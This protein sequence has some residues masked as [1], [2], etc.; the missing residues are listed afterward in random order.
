MNGLKD[1][2]DG[3]IAD[4]DELRTRLEYLEE[5]EASR[6]RAYRRLAKGIEY[7]SHLGT[8][9]G[10]N[11]N[12]FTALCGDIMGADCAF[13]N[14]L[15]GGLL[16][17]LGRW[18]PPPGYEEVDLPEGHI[19]RKVLEFSS[20]EPL[21][22]RDLHLS[23]YAATDPA[24]R[25]HGFRTYIG[26]AVKRGNELR[27]VLCVFYR[28]DYRPTPGD[29]MVMRLL[30]SAIA[31]EDERKRVEER[32]RESEERFR[33]L[34][35]TA[36]D[37]IIVCDEK[38]VISFW[39]KGARDIFGYTEEEI[40]GKSIRILIPEDRVKRY[41]ESLRKRDA[42]GEFRVVGRITEAVGRRVDGS[43]FP[44]ELSVASWHTARGRFYTGIIRDITWR[45]QMEKELKNRNR[46]LEAYAHTLSHDL[47]NSLALLEGYAEAVEESL[48]KGNR[49][50][51]D[52]AL[53]GIT[54][55]SHRMSRYIES[56]LQ[57][58]EAGESTETAVPTDPLEVLKELLEELAPELEEEGAEVTVPSSLPRVTVAPIRLRQVFSNLLDNAVKFTAAAGIKP[59]VVV[60]V[61]LENGQAVFT[62]KDNGPGL[63]EGV[64]D[65]I[66]EPFSRFASRPCPG[67]GIGLSTV[68]RAVEGWGGRVWVESRPG[69]GC[70]F[71][72]T[73]PAS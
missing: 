14:R 59:K 52:A 43:T 24:V 51:A 10:E 41:Y 65:E 38:G 66:F 18:N 47:R 73:A 60:E 63:P 22:L 55:V 49:E 16:V 62:V 37:A 50:A 13:Y 40:L 26:Q 61:R 68:K 7:I 5:L 46:E 1:E 48:E 2:K 20:E 4:P 12:R 64:G 21:V 34:T 36:N 72:F 28:Y 6:K 11:I 56:L 23:S 9:P 45:K 69:E 25:D 27:G 71:H 31:L 3:S 67:L 19:F 57:Y 35:R 53:E 33:V 15:E 32:L 8:D 29:L 58:A 39:N 42:S 30:S 17:T 44:L 54:K 70:S